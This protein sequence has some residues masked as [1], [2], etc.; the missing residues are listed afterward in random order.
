VISHRY[1]L[2]RMGDFAAFS[3]PLAVDGIVGPKMWEAL[4]S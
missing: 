1:Q 3:F 2:D 4:Y